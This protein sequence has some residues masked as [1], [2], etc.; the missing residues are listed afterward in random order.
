LKEYRISRGEV[1]V[2][3]E[4]SSGSLGGDQCLKK[5]ILQ[6]KRNKIFIFRR[7]Q[8]GKGR[9]FQFSEECKKE[10]EGFF[11]FWKSAKRKRK[12]FPIFGRVQKGK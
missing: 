12:V 1:L 2:V 6:G 7:V 8:K 4:W 3:E 9:F 5:G 10:M 11:N